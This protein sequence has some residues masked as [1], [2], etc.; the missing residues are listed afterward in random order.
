MTG[1]LALPRF[2]VHVRFRN[3]HDQSLLDRK[4]SLGWDGQSALFK[5]KKRTWLT[6]NFS[7]P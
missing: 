2:D 3:S 5:W 4:D 7:G 1:R 6:T